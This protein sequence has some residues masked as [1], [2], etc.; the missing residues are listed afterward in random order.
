MVDRYWLSVGSE[1]K[2]PYTLFQLKSMWNSGLITADT[3][4]C[5][6]GFEQWVPFASLFPETPPVAP[7]EAAPP[8][9]DNRILPALV[10]CLFLGVFGAHA[11]YARR[12]KQGVAILVCMLI[13]VVVF[14]GPIFSTS[15]ERI[16]IGDSL[17]AT[18]TYL[19]LC[20]LPL[21]FVVV[22]VLCDLVRTA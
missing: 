6:E 7:Q 15:L 18:R 13:P 9:S 3:I 21:V 19:A 4:Y 16:I 14:F 22:H 20:Y 5:Q 11:F 10:L 1:N 17:V 8:E 12:I 2:G